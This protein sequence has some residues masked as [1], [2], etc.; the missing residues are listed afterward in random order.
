MREIK[1]SKG[2][3]SDLLLEFS[4]ITLILFRR[5]KDNDA[6]LKICNEINQSIASSQNYFVE[7]PEVLSKKANIL[8]VQILFLLVILVVL[9]LKKDSYDKETLSTFFYAYI[10]ATILFI[11]LLIINLILNFINKRQK[12]IL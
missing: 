9:I 12:D 11:M 1:D 6:L 2:V 10:I 3:F 5:K 8:F 7:E 4:T